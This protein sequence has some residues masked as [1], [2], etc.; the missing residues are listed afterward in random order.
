[1]Y[2]KAVLRLLL[3]ILVMVIAGCNHQASDE[4]NSYRIDDVNVRAFILPNGNLDV[5]EFYTYTF[6]DAVHG[7]TRS[8]GQQGHRGISNFQAYA[9]PKGDSIQSI[10]EH[11]E[12]LEL[13]PVQQYSNSKLDTYQIFKSS[14]HETQSFYYHYEIQQVVHKYTDIS[15]LYW[16]FFDQQN[17]STLH[18]VQISITLPQKGSIQDIHAYLKDKYGGTLFFDQN[19]TVYYENK[20]LP[21]HRVSEIRIL[22][23]AQMMSNMQAQPIL[24]KDSLISE[25]DTLAIKYASRTANLEQLG[26]ILN[27]VM[28]GF[29]LLI[30]G[31][32]IWRIYH[33][34]RA[35]N[36]RFAVG[37]LE[38]TDP[39]LLAYLWHPG[40][41]IPE[42][43]IAS[44]FSLYRRNVITIETVP[45]RLNYLHDSTAPDYT[46]RFSIKDVISIP[47][48]KD[49]RYLLE[50]LFTDSQR[51]FTLDTLAGPTSQEKHD[52][53]RMEY[54]RVQYKKFYKHYRKWSKQVKKRLD[55]NSYYHAPMLLCPI[56]IMLTLLHAGMLAYLYVI[57]I[58]PSF[59]TTIG[60]TSLI[61]MTGITIVYYRSKFVFTLYMI[62]YVLIL[63]LGVTISE[64]YSLL[65]WC[66]IL[67]L[68]GRYVLPNK[69]W[70]AQG[71]PYRYGIKSFRE[72]LRTGGYTH[73]NNPE[74]L[75]LLLQYSIILKE[76]TSFL[77]TH[78]Q[79]TGYQ[80]MSQTVPLLSWAEI[81]TYTIQY[82]YQT[83]KRSTYS[84]SD[85]STI[86][87]PNYR[88]DSDQNHS[89]SSSNHSSG[90]GGGA[91]TF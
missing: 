31:G 54:Y 66:S 69:V 42:D 61:I 32:L 22:F 71:L 88:N 43:I 39:L 18:N 55:W 87:T 16:S 78:P 30:I 50:W 47:L 49:E 1:M 89:D 65:L 10:I 37:E 29:I 58:L 4:E 24:A 23:P 86:Y 81:N 35:K 17:S 68:I 13:L 59:T 2:Q 28:I 34:R 73:E 85:S 44:L 60:L 82:T 7:T 77:A 63:T 14:V 74:Q 8:I 45:I 56:C 79:L 11:P 57:D 83:M 33:H 75:D 48:Q 40:Q 84:P 80:H 15:D 62:V 20:E 6:L 70:T 19:R 72:Q 64:V 9:I 52:P 3:I 38:H 5:H 41:I 46:L 67:L 53:E 91:G 12:R 36:A 25:E 76:G 27:L 21:A 90:G 26:S 51:S